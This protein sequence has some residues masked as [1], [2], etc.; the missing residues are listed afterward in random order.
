MGPLSQLITGGK[1]MVSDNDGK[2]RVFVLGSG[3]R[4]FLSVVRSL[5]RR[6]LEVYV[7]SYHFDPAVLRSRYITKVNYLPSPHDG[8]AWRASM[9]E[10]LS[11]KRFQLIIPTD[12]PTTIL[13]RRYRAELEQHCP[14]YLLDERAYATTNDKEKTYQLARE[15]GVNVPRTV[16]LDATSD[17]SAVARELGFPLMLKPVSSFEED[18]LESKRYVKRVRDMDE[19]TS[20][21]EK[22]SAQGPV[23]A[24]EFFQGV[25]AGIE[26]LAYHGEILTS[27][28]HV[29]VHEPRGGG[30]STY[31]RS[32]PV[33][34]ELLE[35]SRTIITA[36][37]YTGVCM[38]EFRTDRRSGGW[39]LI[40][41]NGR[42]WGSLP[43]A[44][45]S[46]QDFPYYLYQML[47]QGKR[48][49]P[50]GY[51]KNIYCRNTT[52]DV[53]WMKENLRSSKMQL[54]SE[55]SN[56]L[57]L[58]ERNDTLVMDDL[59]P[60]VHEAYTN[61]RSA[62][63]AA[64]RAVQ[65]RLMALPM[66]RESRS[67]K[68]KSKLEVAKS[69]IFVCKGN[70]CRSP[71]AEHYARKTLPSGITVRSCGTYQQDGRPSPE[72]AIGSASKFGV[73]LVEHR[74]DCIDQ[75]MLKDADIIFV[76]D[77]ENMS[78]LT[79]RYPQ[80]RSKVHLLSDLCPRS[81]LFIQD[82]YGKDM[83]AFD[84]AYMQIVHNL[85]MASG[86]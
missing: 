25:G 53:A 69:V 45:A 41:I 83:E 18:D 67:K 4:A 61:V 36:L 31:R 28:E 76:F 17:L 34:P 21:F 26:V 78:K 44:V 84:K 16:P 48:E 81:P 63:D 54:L 59:G 24:Q 33:D 79:Q 12:D 49:F 23:M 80:A 27:F 47:V 86:G 6:G 43:L 38:L 74:S 3:T 1:N 42:F 35:A 40:E 72:E 51:R 9:V 65:L 77:W 7:G 64:Q 8:E 71:F 57:M 82:P 29:R 14:A 68:L 22:M 62:Y 10:L 60:G 75:D 73:D 66:A 32:V 5:G 50:Q 52:L 46:G 30:V 13:C 11:G 20:T 15:L 2:D 39:V 55:M 19:L 70:I 56:V 58:R 85:N 37:D